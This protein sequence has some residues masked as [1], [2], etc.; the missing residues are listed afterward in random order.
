M[1]SLGKGC[2]WTVKLLEETH[3][4]LNDK[5]LDL[6][7]LSKVNDFKLKGEILYSKS[8]L[9]RTEE[10]INNIKTD[11]QNSRI[12]IS[13]S[14]IDEDEDEKIYMIPN[15]IG[16]TKAITSLTVDGKQLLVPFD[17]EQWKQD[18]IKEYDNN[19]EI[20]SYSNIDLQE[21]KKNNNI[22]SKDMVNMEEQSW[23]KLTDL[24]TKIHKIFED[25]FND[26]E[27]TKF[28]DV[29]D[30]VYNSIVS[31]INEFKNSLKKKYPGCQFYPELGIKSKKLS[32]DILAELEASGKDSING[33]IDLLVIDGNGNG[34]LYDYKVSRKDISPND[35]ILFGWDITGNKIIRDKK[36][37]D[38]TKKLAAAYQTE[39][40]S[41]MLKQ[42]GVN[43]VDTNILHVKL[44]LEYNNKSNPFEITNVNG[45]KVNY[46]FVISNPGKMKGGIYAARIRKMFDLQK[47]QNEADVMKIAEIY[48]CFFPKN[49][50][51]LA[52]E[53]AKNN[54]EYYKKND[55]YV[56][57]LKPGEFNY[58]KYKYRLKYYG[59][60]SEYDYCN[61]D[62]LGSKLSDYIYKKK[63]STATDCISI[64][65]SIESVKSGEDTSKLYNLVPLSSRNFLKTSLSKYL[66]PEWTYINDKKL[67]ALGIY[68]FKKGNKCEI[69]SLTKEAL[70]VKQNIGLGTSILGKTKSDKYINFKEVLPALNGN[71]ELM[72]VMVFINQNQD[73]FKDYKISQIQVI[74]PWAGNSMSQLNST[75]I[76]N[77]NKL[78]MESPTS[79]ATRMSYSLFFDDTVA[80]VEQAKD[81]LSNLDTILETGGDTHNVY[82]ADWFAQKIDLFEQYYGKDLNL[83]N[84]YQNTPEWNA[85]VKLKEGYNITRGYKTF[86]ESDRHEILNENVHELNGLLVS[87]PQYSSSSNI[88]ELGK[89]IDDYAKEVRKQVFELGFPLQIAFKKLY[90]K[91]GT[92]AKVFNS[93]FADRQKLILK[94]PN[95]SEFDGDQIARETLD[96]VLK[97][98]AKLRN[99]DL[100]TDE[101]FEKAK[102]D[103]E[104][105]MLPLLEAKA[106][107]Q[108]KNLGLW[109]T[110]KNKFKENW[111][112]TKNLFMGEELDEGMETY[113]TD[114]QEL[115]NKLKYSSISERESRLQTYESG[116]FET[117]IEVVMNAALVAF[118]R[119]NV[120]K[121]YI[122]CISGMKMALAYNDMHSGI[123]SGNIER[124]MKH[125]RETF[126]KMVKSKFYGESI[127]DERLRP[128]LKWINLI[129]STFTTMTL[130]LNVRSFLRESLQGAYLGATRAGVHLYPGINEK[131]YLD[132]LEY[133]IQT[134]HKNFSGVSML[135]QL[136]AVYGMANQSLNQLAE[137]R[138]VNWANINHWGKNT[139]FL[140]ATSPDFMHR[141]GILIAKM[142]GD[143]C[144]DAH[145]IDENGKLV[146]D[147]KKDKRFTHLVNNET[148][149]PDYLKEKSLY[150]TMIDDFNT[151]G[152]RN[153]DGSLLNA[154]KM[155]AL[156]QAYTRTEGQSLKNYADLLYGHYDEESKSLL[157][158]TFIGSIFLQYKTYITAKLEQW[159][160]HEGVYNTEQLQQQFD[161]NGKPL[162][163]KYG[164][165]EN[166]EPYKDV[167]LE[168]EYNNLSDEDKKSCRLYYDYTGMPMQGMLQESWK[169][170]SALYKLDSEKLKKL[171][172]DPTSRIMFQLAM[173]DTFFMGLMIF[174]TNIIFGNIEDVKNPV[175]NP[176]KVYQ[177][178]KKT[179]PIEN[180]VYNVINGSMSDFM[181]TNIINSFTDKPPVI[182]AA[183]RFITSSMNL[184]TGNSSIT[185]WLTKNIGML[186]D[187]EG[188]TDQINNMK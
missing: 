188:L 116:M 73:L 172:N 96:L 29:S 152:F 32:P 183:N 115:Y 156:P 143:G 42:Y 122:P 46:N 177:A 7:L 2:T 83:Q 176:S 10:C 138:R 14:K 78:V 18:K 126:D 101:D 187:F 76:S 163:V 178:V 24:G 70:G 58:G 50:T 43:V 153:A 11:L 169:F 164:Y 145:S 111:T 150:C 105:Y 114:N 40:Y 38:S 84:G 119:Y 97:T 102:Q 131:N 160:M 104:Y 121:E 61:D 100:K 81:E 118:C 167:L 67:N 175:I 28:D 132:G 157:C 161:N 155:D 57:E 33:V 133:V 113:A 13:K 142:K 94:D 93:W 44:D 49:S 74:N 135:Q 30:E 139:L 181:F 144:F 45:V 62:T 64:G 19:E 90:D 25:I 162:Y 86:I 180:L 22:S 174:L 89:V 107:R 159:T 16:V 124:N 39:I 75:L 71:L 48:N 20:T 36:L 179:G 1:K 127:V 186:R 98:L 35:D 37:W 4:G 34:H 54:I 5:D 92:G 184:I 129:K 23:P 60:S 99:P 59:V 51:I 147:F 110:I 123:K 68:I 65:N 171:W 85:Y 21:F 182:S 79:G 166:N 158:D 3:K 120:S 53:E 9:E 109:K 154:E 91:Y 165:D 128:L 41:Q 26:K 55:R 66:N 146:Y 80:L 82:S 17:K 6:F 63:N 31:Q 168:S 151:A 108:I 173:H 103:P 130:S 106:S 117:D 95:S 134:A 125:I 72:K 47:E 140:T 69:V 185:N 56:H 52:R 15:S 87:S 77:Y 27:P 112:V 149:H 88:R 148:T 137:E 141:M 136:N 12:E 170:I 8:P